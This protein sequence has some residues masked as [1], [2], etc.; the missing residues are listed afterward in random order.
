MI[1]QKIS[2]YRIL[3]VLGGGGMD[4]VYG[5]RHQAPPLR[6]VEIPAGRSG[7]ESSAVFSDLGIQGIWPIFLRAQ[8]Y[9]QAKRGEEAAE[10]FRRSM[11][12]CGE[13][14]SVSTSVGIK[15]VI[16][17]MISRSEASMDPEIWFAASSCVVSGK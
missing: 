6:C 17:V 16:V 2:H 8:P 12:S 15:K 1:G 4:V 14:S 7:Q 11:K 13:P 3:E 5:R 10:E 9:L